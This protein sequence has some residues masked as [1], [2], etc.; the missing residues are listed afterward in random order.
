MINKTTENFQDSF[1][2]KPWAVNLIVVLIFIFGF[3]IR[4]L[5]LTDPPLD[6]TPTRSM[7]SAI[8]ARGFYYQYAKNAPEWQRE[9]AI[10]QA[11]NAAVLEPPVSETIVAG[12]Y[13]I[14]GE[15]LWIARIFSSVSW[16]L[17]GLALFS[18]ARRIA[19]IDGAMVALLYFLFV[20][21]GVF[22]SRAFQPD[23]LMVTLIIAGLWAF[24]NWL[25]KKTWK[26]VLITGFLSGMAIFVKV[27]AAFPLFAAFALTILRTQGLKAAVKNPQ[28]WVLALLTPLPTVIYMIDGIYLSG[29]LDLQYGL[30]FFPNLWTDPGFYVRWKN[31]LGNTLGFG[32]FLLALIGVYLAKPG[33]E[34]SLLL[35]FLVGYLAFGFT[36]AYH[37]GTH[38]YYQLQLIIFISLSLAVVAKVVFQYLKKI[39]DRTVFPRLFVAG[40]IIFGVGS[41]MWNVRVELVRQDFRPEARFWADL[42]STLGRS[43][44]VIGLT[45][46]YGHNLAYWGWKDIELWPTTGDQ[47]L[48]ELAGKESSFEE[49]FMERTTGKQFFV[50]TLFNQFDQQPELKDFLYENYPIYDQSDDYIIFDLQHPIEQP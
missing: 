25:E 31:I 16:L 38:S 15:H 1:F 26:W 42:G 50:V 37:I 3:G 17:G 24:E 48:R 46:N 41:E 27:M 7:L 18:L 21:F 40:I 13:L 11:E 28:V 49:V 29:Y 32:A 14:F 20:D 10:Q 6:F 45:Q 36:F 33:K 22:A 39:N 4:M 34:R 2:G 47:N 23:P 44:H 12:L 8:K 43:S 30:W 5:D 35:G 9:I 19:S